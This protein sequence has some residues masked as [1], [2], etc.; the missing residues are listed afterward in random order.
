MTACPCTALFLKRGGADVSVSEAVLITPP[1]VAEMVT[2]RSSH[3]A[4][5]SH[6]P[7]PGGFRF[8]NPHVLCVQFVVH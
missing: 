1:Y 8:C 3:D 6:L 2:G 5:S 4:F 7:C